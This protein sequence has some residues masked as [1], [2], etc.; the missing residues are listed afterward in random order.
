MALSPGDKLGP[1]EI[2]S[3]LGVGG[4]GEVYEARDTRL[5]CYGSVRGAVSDRRP[6][7][8]S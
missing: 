4:Q 3:L 1:Y 5:D 6:Y 8:D 2:L 7:R